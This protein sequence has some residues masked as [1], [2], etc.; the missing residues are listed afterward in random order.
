LHSVDIIH[1]RGW[2]NDAGQIDCRGEQ[3]KYN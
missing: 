3:Q 2:G 1:Q